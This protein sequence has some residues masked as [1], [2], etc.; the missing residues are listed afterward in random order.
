MIKVENKTIQEQYYKEV[1][2]NGLTVYLMP[3]TEFYKTY[4]VFATKYG[5]RDTEFVPQGANEF[6]K[7]P[8][9]IAHFLEHKLFEMQDGTDASNLFATYGA[10]VNAFTTNSQTAYLFST[11]SD[12]YKC[13]ELLLDFVQTPYFNNSSIKK[14]QGII[15]Q[16]LLMYLDQPQNIQYYG[17]LKALYKENSI[18][19]EIGG[20]VFSIKEIDEDL[21]Y[22]CYN[23]FYHPSNMV[24]TITGNFE[25]YE[26]LNLIKKNQKS[27]VFDKAMPIKRKYIL[28]DQCVNEKNSYVDMNVIVPK[29][30]LGLKFPYEKLEVKA[31]LKRFA[32]LELLVD[33]YFD[34][35]TEY[36][37]ELITKGFINNS[38]E[39]SLYY[40]ETYGHLLFNLD[41]QDP[42]KFI[43]K[44]K[45]IINIIKNKEINNND[46]K[47]LKRLYQARSIKRFN[48][49]EYIA[50]SIVEAHNDGHTIFDYIDILNEITIKDLENVKN[51]F[52]EDSIS[53]FIIYPQKNN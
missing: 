43:N 10:D 13:V 12:V 34:E 14:E 9:G 50:N 21:L 45:S 27:K 24:L 35:S 15:E 17:I 38:F 26:M 5:S 2:D 33:L 22:T 47:L 20:T 1:L 16:E 29:A 44:I 32:S 8:E 49:L 11:T 23:T 46:F 39:Y 19:N 4:A 52:N 7:T 30:T 6:I 41:T 28:E 36:F 25:L 42:D 18:R 31:S 48:S 40:D 37:E 3:K 53:T 51:F